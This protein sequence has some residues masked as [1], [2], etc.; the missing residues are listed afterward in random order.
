MVEC[1]GGIRVEDNTGTS[2]GEFFRDDSFSADSSG[3]KRM[4]M[5]RIKDGEEVGWG[6]KLC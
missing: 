2:S 1:G 4:S 6:R 5:E 3:R